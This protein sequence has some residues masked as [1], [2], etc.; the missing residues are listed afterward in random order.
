M[1]Y[2]PSRHRVSDLVKV[3]VKIN[4]ELIKPLSFLT[5]RKNALENARKLLESL[6]KRLKRQQY[7]LRIY[8]C[9]GQSILTSVT[10]SSVRKDVTEKCYGGDYSRKLKLLNKQKEGKDRLAQAQLGKG[11]GRVTIEKEAFLALLRMNDEQ[12]DNKEE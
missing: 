10:L 6:K 7:R 8:A 1:S 5:P 12:G 2:T 3:D 4:E 11:Q 9:V